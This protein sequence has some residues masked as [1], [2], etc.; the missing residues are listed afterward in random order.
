MIPSPQRRHLQRLPRIWSKHPV[1]SL[2]TCVANRRRLLDRPQAGEILIAAWRSAPRYHG[3]VIGRYV[4]MPDHVH[5]F[6]RP[7]PEAKPLK[8]FMRDWKKW[9]ARK[10]TDKQLAAPPIWQPEF[11]DHVIRTAESYAEKW[12]Y[13]WENPVRAGLAS[14]G[15]DW[16]FSGECEVLQF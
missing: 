5:F 16:P 9:T 15:E 6:A 8:D 12:R 3:W 2:T 7:N 13:V 4:V 10:L 11:F 14:S 1:Y